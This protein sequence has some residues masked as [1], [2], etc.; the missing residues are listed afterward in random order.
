[1]AVL[2][3]AVIAALPIVA[4][5]AFVKDRIATAARDAIGRNL[6]IAG[7]IE[8]SLFPPV[9]V[10]LGDVRLANAPGA[11]ADN[12]VTIGALDISI[13]A[14]ASIDGAV[15]IDLMTVNDPKIWL[16]ANVA[17]RPNWDIDSTQASTGSAVGGQ[18]SATSPK[19]IA[20]PEIRVGS[21]RIEGGARS[22][23]RARGLASRA[24]SGS[25]SRSRT[26]AGGGSRAG[27]SRG[28][29]REEIGPAGSR[30]NPPGLARIDDALV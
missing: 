24:C 6:T 27:P 22:G 11:A 23:A 20:P 12:M 16:E 13:D 21:I 2:A 19:S 14:M 25:C 7:D 9:H 26:C 29:G 4:N 15:I 3:I 8:V 17:G 18:G 10:V 5:T 30:W 1:V 28:S